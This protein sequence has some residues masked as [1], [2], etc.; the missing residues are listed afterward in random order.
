MD[1]YVCEVCSN[2]LS[3]QLHLNDEGFTID[4][5]DQ[6]SVQPLINIWD[7]PKVCITSIMAQLSSHLGLYQ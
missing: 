3:A 6:R 7:A 2:F 4:S 1:M 5:D